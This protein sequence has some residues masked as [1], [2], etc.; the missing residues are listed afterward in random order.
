MAPLAL[1]LTGCPSKEIDYR[2]S[3]VTQ[4]CS[5]AVDP[6]AGVT[7]L[8]VRVLAADLQSPLEATSAVSG[9]ERKLT[10][11]AILPG[12]GRVLEVRGCAELPCTKSKTVS[13][14]RT[15]PFDV[16]DVVP[17]P[18]AAPLNFTVFLRRVGAFT[19][20]SAPSSPTTCASLR[21]AR[22]GHTATLD[23]L[24]RVFI[25]GGF[26]T[27]SS[28]Q[29]EATPTTEFFDPLKGAFI[30]GPDL[31]LN[32]GG[33]L[34]SPRAFHTATLMPSSGAIVIWGGENYVGSSLAVPLSTALVFNPEAALPEGADISTPSA[35]GIIAPRTDAGLGDGGSVPTARAHHAAA[36]DGAGRLVIIG[37]VART[38]TV[39]SAVGQIEW[40]NF[41]STGVSAE[42]GQGSLPRMGVSVAAVQDGGFIA[43]GGGTDGTT[44]AD[45]ITYLRFRE[46]TY[47]VEP[48]ASPTRL[49]TPRRSAGAGVWAKTNDFILVGG[50][51]DVAQVSPLSNAE[52]IKTD[53][54]QASDNRMAVG[55]RGDVCVAALSDSALFAVGG[56]TADSPGSSPYADPTSTVLER[57]VRGNPVASPGPTLDL[58][59]WGHT[60]TTLGDGTV[61][62]VGGVNEAKGSTTTPKERVI[63]DV[64]I[65]Q[66]LP[67]D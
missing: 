7:H 58:S 67:K 36:V 23:R 65:Y 46:G 2:L 29:R 11:P 34:R 61:L 31:S 8:S 53:A 45:E 13:M 47:K 21:V 20:P 14:G 64:Q 19:P 6:L 28:G 38:G 5:A 17:D 42:V 12:K 32:A 4:V 63:A 59:R 35:F 25:A 43:V 37:G 27:N 62:I 15:L 10:L 16:P 51:G 54:N 1:V 55:S 41:Q 26:Q 60:C 24:G 50:Y 57:D 49:R 56:R 9:G 33:N 39:T 18:G 40:L 3:V 22:A 30:D 48:L 44:L 52:I 66:P